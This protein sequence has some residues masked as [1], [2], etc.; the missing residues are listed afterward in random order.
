[1]WKKVR[2]QQP[3]ELCVLVDR[4]HQLDR[5]R[6]PVCGFLS[7]LLH[8][9][10]VWVVVK[11][12]WEPPSKNNIPFSPHHVLSLSSACGKLYISVNYDIEKKNHFV[13]LFS[14]SSIFCC[15]FFFHLVFF[16][17]NC[18][19]FNMWKT[20]V[21]SLCPSRALKKSFEFFLRYVF[22]MLR[23]LYLYHIT[24]NQET[25]IPSLKQKKKFIVYSPWGNL[26]KS[27]WID[28]RVSANWKKLKKE[29]DLYVF[30]SSRHFYI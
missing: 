14:S 26:K 23:V 27:P 16:F 17:F 9:N 11:E 4:L 12:K 13:A 30:S 10:T 18:N 21:L 19:F 25:K 2:Q 8:I 7:W 3:G 24:R 29:K 28:L 20:N 6:A 22:Y 1:M 15:F 5:M